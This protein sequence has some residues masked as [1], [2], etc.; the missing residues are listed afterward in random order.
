MDLYC[1][2]CQV[3][4]ATLQNHY[5]KYSYCSY[6]QIF[7]LETVLRHFQKLRSVFLDH[8]LVQFHKITPYSLLR[9]ETE[10]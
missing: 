3:K 8:K 2:I 7:S 10:N 6:L 1:T 9:K 4:I 5:S